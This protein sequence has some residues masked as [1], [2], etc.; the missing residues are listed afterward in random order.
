MADFTPF[1]RTL[2]PPPVQRGTPGTPGALPQ[3]AATET[4][5]AAQAMQ[6]SGGAPAPQNP[7]TQPTADQVAP[8]PP[9][10]PS[11]D[12][13]KFLFAKSNR[14][15]ESVFAGMGAN[16]G[17]IAPPSDLVD[18]L[19]AWQKAALT[20]GPGQQQAQDILNLLTFNLNK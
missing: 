10:R 8:E 16:N 12:D 15:G 6:P 5:N 20:P 7:A 11:T 13:E 18:S 1:L 14:P 19:P 2:A 3:G 17:R 4:N 9:F